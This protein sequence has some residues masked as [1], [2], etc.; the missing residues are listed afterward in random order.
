MHGGNPDGNLFG[1]DPN[2]F[3]LSLVHDYI[4]NEKADGDVDLKLSHP[5]V[6]DKDGF[7]IFYSPS[8]PHCVNFA[9][10]LQK[11]SKRLKGSCAIGTVNCNDSIHGNQLLAD[12]YNV[13]GIPTIKFYNHITG[14]YID[15]TGGRTVEDMLAFLCK[16]RNLCGY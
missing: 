8:C 6:K 1:G 9:P 12:F 13:S 2:I 7:I 5:A 11:L 15:Y 14:E 3:E 10:T 4:L 16:V